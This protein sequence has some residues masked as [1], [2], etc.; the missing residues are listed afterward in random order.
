MHP[1]GTRG[2][3]L[4]VRIE[5]DRFYGPGIYDMKGGA[6]LAF[7]AFKAAAK[8]APQLPLAQGVHFDIP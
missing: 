6:H 5:G 4:P 7:Q 1:V 3:G 8:A 2:G